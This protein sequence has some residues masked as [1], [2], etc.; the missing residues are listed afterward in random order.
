MRRG[1]SLLVAA[2]YYCCCQP[3]VLFPVSEVSRRRD[4]TLSYPGP[5]PEPDCCRTW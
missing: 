4:R 2:G 3:L 5:S 1:R